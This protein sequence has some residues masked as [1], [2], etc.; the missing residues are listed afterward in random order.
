MDL[1]FRELSFLF[2]RVPGDYEEFEDFSSSYRVA[3]NYL[4][5]SYNYSSSYPPNGKLSILTV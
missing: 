5:Y 3:H 4:R 2:M 1:I